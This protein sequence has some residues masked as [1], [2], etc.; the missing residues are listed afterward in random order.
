[1]TNAGRLNLP[2][3]EASLR[4]LQF[5]FEAVNATL[6]SPRDPLTDEVL[7]RLLLGYGYVDDLLA[8]N[9]DLFAAGNSRHL[10]EIN[11]LVLCGRDELTRD[12]CRQLVEAT[13]ERF[14]ANHD[15]GVG[16]LI[17]WVRMMRAETV[18]RQA[19]SAYIH[20]LSQPQLFIEGN[21][22]A[23]S[24]IMSW[25]LARAGKPPF[26]LSVENAKAYFDPSTLAKNARKNT[27]NM[28][29]RRPKLMKRF[30]DLLKV[31]AQ[32]AYVL[33]PREAWR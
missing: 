30:A 31:E 25:I 33:Q 18:W 3:I 12:E 24:L 10:L 1:M 14:Y 22:R 32:P 9:I 21:H 7:H 6:S 8:N 2:A 27:L 13:E 20:I 23:G 29:L 26:V 4:A 28:M 19:A 15:G 5:D 11:L 17:S 16:E